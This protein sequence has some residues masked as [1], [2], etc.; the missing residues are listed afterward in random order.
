MRESATTPALI[1]SWRE[2]VTA[3]GRRG[4]ETGIGGTEGTGKDGDPVAQTKTKTA[5]NAKKVAAAAEK[6]GVSAGRKKERE[7]MT[8]AG[9]RTGNT[10][11]TEAPKGRSPEIRRAGGRQTIGGIR[12]IGTGT[13]KRGGPKGRAGVG[14]ETGSIEVEE[15]RRAGKGSAATAERGTESEMVSSVLTSVVVAKRRATISESPVTTIVN[16]TNAEGVRALSERGLT[17]V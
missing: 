4:T 6:G 11:R 17:A 10:I 9:R 14:A 3:R 1:G 8:G 15:R 12:M 16:P 7:G 5:E 13:G 2:S